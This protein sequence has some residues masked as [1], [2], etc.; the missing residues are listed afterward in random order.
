MAKPIEW[1]SVRVLVSK[2][3]PTPNNYKIKTELGRERLKLSLKKFGLAGTVVLNSDYSLIDGNS[4][5][6]E[7]KLK[8][9][10][11]IWASMPNRKLSPAEY[12]EMSALYDFAKA[13]EVDMDRI[14]GE[15]G[16]SADFRKEW[17]LA[18][19]QEILDQIG[20]GGRVNSTSANGG[21]T[22]EVP[23]SDTRIINII[24][25]PQQEAAILEAEAICAKRFKTDNITDTVMAALI[26][27]S[28]LKK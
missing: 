22:K 15:L 13:G 27:I 8:K 9:E 16:T 23:K 10:K 19:P 21:A 7:A 6:E 5:W 4:R 12:K 2:I 24:M 3:T 17:A 18:V 11:Y 20:K 28:K 25:N 26:F 1:N 14:H